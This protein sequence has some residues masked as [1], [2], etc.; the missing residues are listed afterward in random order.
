MNS[1]SLKI[2]L[3]NHPELFGFIIIILIGLIFIFIIGGLLMD[4]FDIIK[5]RFIKEYR[6]NKEFY[7]HYRG[8]IWDEFFKC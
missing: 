5:F 2:E 1:Y 7:R 3:I 8:G 4:L 6:E